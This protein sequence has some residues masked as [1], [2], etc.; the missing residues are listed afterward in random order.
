MALHNHS[1][2][3]M[4]DLRLFTTDLWREHRDVDNTGFLYQ[5]LD[6]NSIGDPDKY[7]SADDGLAN[8]MDTDNLTK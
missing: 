1:W 7:V 8:G 6:P 4:N 2:Q 3:T 5:R